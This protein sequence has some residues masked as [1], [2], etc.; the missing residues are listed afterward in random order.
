MHWGN[1]NFSTT[2]RKANSAISQFLQSPHFAEDPT[3]SYHYF[4]ANH[5]TPL[6]SRLFGSDIPSSLWIIIWR[7]ERMYLRDCQ[8]EDLY[9]LAGW[10]F[11]TWILRGDDGRKVCGGDVILEA[12]I[13]ALCFGEKRGGEIS[14]SVSKFQC[15]QFAEIMGCLIFSHIYSSAFWGFRQFIY[16]IRCRLNLFDFLSSSS[17]IKLTLFAMWTIL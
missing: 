15:C 10:A 12:L 4:R 2:Q 1:S 5:F 13:W 11:H 6:S 16:D 17:I 7:D 9:H 14:S 3:C 8:E